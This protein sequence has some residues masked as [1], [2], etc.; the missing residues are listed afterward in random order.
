MNWQKLI[1]VMLQRGTEHNLLA[2]LS[3][4]WVTAFDFM[5]EFVFS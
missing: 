2:G 3:I 5:R 4:R 1:I